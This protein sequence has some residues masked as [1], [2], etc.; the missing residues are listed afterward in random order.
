LAHLGPV[1]LDDEAGAGAEDAASLEERAG[2]GANV[3]E[4]Q[5]LARGIC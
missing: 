1:E 4:H 3:E 5:L 2:A